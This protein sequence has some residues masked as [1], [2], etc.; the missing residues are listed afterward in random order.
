MQRPEDHHVKALQFT[1]LSGL[2]DYLFCS[3]DPIE[4]TKL[5][6]HVVN[7]NRVELLGAFQPHNDNTR[8]CYAVATCQKNTFTFNQYMAVEEFIVCMQT[9]FDQNQESEAIINL[10]G[11]IVSERVKT[12]EDN[13]FAQSVQVR[14]GLTT[15]SQVVIENPVALHPWRTFTEIN[16]PQI[17]AV[18]RFKEGADHQ[19]MVA[20]FDSACEWWRRDAIKAIKEWLV[21]QVETV[22]VLA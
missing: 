15:K 6:F 14:T 17:H 8:F 20:L 10:V 16:Q 11:N 5:F 13:G 19:L 12:H 2:V 4:R 21:D 18:L 22:P 9:D 1:T 7:Y 3:I